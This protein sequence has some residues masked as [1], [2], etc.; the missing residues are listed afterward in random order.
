MSCGGNGYQGPALGQRTNDDD[1]DDDDEILQAYSVR[2][3]WVGD[4]FSVPSVKNGCI[5]SAVD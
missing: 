3:V 2:K 4:Q 5:R 1:D